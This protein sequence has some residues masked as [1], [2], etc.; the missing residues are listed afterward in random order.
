MSRQT[1]RRSGLVIATA[2]LSL[3]CLVSTDAFAGG[4]FVHVSRFVGATFA[5]VQTAPSQRQ[6]PPETNMIKEKH[7]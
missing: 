2:M 6:R 7:R 1:S 4:S 5:A 3:A